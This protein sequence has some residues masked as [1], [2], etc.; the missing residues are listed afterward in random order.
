MAHPSALTRRGIALV[1]LLAPALLVK[2]ALAAPAPGLLPA[3]T[4]LARLVGLWRGDGEGEPGVSTV[5]RI[6]EP[7]LGGHFL[8]SQN[9]STYAPQPKNLKGEVHQDVGFYSYDKAAKS[10]VFRQFHVEGYVNQFTA[11]AD[12][13]TG[14][15]LAFTTV[16]IENIPAGYQAR[17][18]ITFHGPDAFEEVFEIA[19]PGKPFAV[20]SHNRM[21]RVST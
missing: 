14:D 19:E 12:S 6:Y 5:E 9:T 16:F 4:P 10:V 13:L 2:P 3:L 17:E 21:R 8:K 11:S 1:G 20:Y 7:A 15:V 18:S